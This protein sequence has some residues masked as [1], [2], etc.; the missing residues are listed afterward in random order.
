MELNSLLKQAFVLHQSRSWGNAEDGTG[1][2]WKPRTK[3]YGAL[4]VPLP[5]M[6][7]RAD[8]PFRGQKGRAFRSQEVTGDV[9][10]P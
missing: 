4:V 2:G 6:Q 8:F 5:V 3:V 1:A 7:P 9:P 10:S